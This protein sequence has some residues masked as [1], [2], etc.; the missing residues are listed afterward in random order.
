[1]RFLLLARALGVDFERTATIGRQWLSTT[2][3]QAQTVLNSEWNTGIDAATLTSLLRSDYVDGLLE[4]LGANH[5]H[6]FDYSNY[7]GATHL[8]DFNLPIDAS[9]FGQYSVVFDGGSLEHVFN[10]PVAIANCMKMLRVGGHYLAITPTNNYMGHGLYQ[11]SPE[12]YFRIFSAENG[13]RTEHI[14]LVQGNQT[15]RWFRVTDPGTAKKRFGLEDSK[16]TQLYVIATKIA[17]RTPFASPPLQSDYTAVWETEPERRSGS[18][19]RNIRRETRPHAFLP[20]RLREMV[21]WYEDTRSR[22]T[23]QRKQRKKFLTAF[24]PTQGATG[25]KA[26]PG[27]SKV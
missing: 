20:A 8:H 24:D 4:H 9:A 23:R 5:V 2:F 17:E 16:R 10:F 12:L 21:D 26:L 27:V 7:E 18:T 11:F 6:S 3:A 22:L 13:F 15:T 19:N 25:I 1:M 14:L